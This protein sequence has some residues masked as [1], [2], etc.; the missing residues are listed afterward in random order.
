LIEHQSALSDPP[1]APPRRGRPIRQSGAVK[2][3]HVRF[4]S[5]ADIRAAKSDVRFTLETGL[6]SAKRNV[7]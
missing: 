2:R 1:I 6:C 4:G 7:C 3:W 5:K